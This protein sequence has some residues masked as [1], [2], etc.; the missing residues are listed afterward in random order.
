MLNKDLEQTLNQAFVF[1]REHRHEF[2]TVEHLL[3]ALL[4]N[5]SARDALRACG[6]NIDSIK[7]ELTDFVKDTTPFRWP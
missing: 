6:A 3:L 2:M 1:A 7:A 5:I 4:D